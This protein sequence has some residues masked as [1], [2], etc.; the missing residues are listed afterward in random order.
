ME[1]IN[2][3]YQFALN[4]LCDLFGDFGIERKTFDILLTDGM[5]K[6]LSV[7]D[8]YNAVLHSIIYAAKEADKQ[9]RKEQFTVI[10]GG[11]V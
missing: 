7:A 4:R 5:A 3:E 11:K 2:T 1:R 8:S 6:G 9:E 10:K